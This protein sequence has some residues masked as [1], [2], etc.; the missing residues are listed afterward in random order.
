MVMKSLHFGAAAVA[1]LLAVSPAL[2]Q[3][4]AARF[5][6]GVTAGSLGVGPEVGF[7]PSSMFGARASAS[8]F[9]LSHDFDVDDID[10]NGK[11]KLESYG[12]MLDFYPF[13]GG[14]RLSG[15]FRVNNNRV[16]VTATPT[17]N[18]TVGDVT[19]TPAQV[20]TLSGHVDTK[21]FA[22]VVTIGYAGGLT[23]GL[24]FGIDAG[25]MFQGEP[26]V[27][28]LRATGALAN[29]TAFLAELDRERV[30]FNDDIDDYKYYPVVQLSLFYAF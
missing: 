22:P 19:Y 11:V 27:R 17:G 14:F 18:V 12:A 3:D 20:G 7:R 13:Q 24:K 28:D 4:D 29:D 5:S 21:D 2:A 9:D 25:V 15:G 1:A 16:G 30:K 23:R 8:F 26:Q 6:V 10:Y